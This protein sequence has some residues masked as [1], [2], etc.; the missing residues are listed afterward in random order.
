MLRSTVSRFR[1]SIVVLGCTVLGASLATCWRATDSG[2]AAASAAE[3]A[4]AAGAEIWQVS[5]NCTRPFFVRAL[6]RTK[7]ELTAYY[8]LAPEQVSEARV[9]LSG[10]TIPPVADPTRAAGLRQRQAAEH[11]AALHVKNAEWYTHVAELE[12]QQSRWEQRLRNIA[13]QKVILGEAA[14]RSFHDYAAGV[15]GRAGA[16]G[17]FDH[18]ALILLGL[19]GFPAAEEQAI[20]SACVTVSPVRQ[21]TVAANAFAAFWP[22]PIEHIAAVAFGLQ[23]VLLGLLLIPTALW[24]ATGDLQAAKQHI[25]LEAKMLLAR[26]REFDGEK[27]VANLLSA[28]RSVRDFLSSNGTGCSDLKWPP[29]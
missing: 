22:T 14:R 7:G 8:N 13:D 12:I 9:R 29:L 16:K 25:H 1:L 18:Y 6:L 10:E 27:F 5:A 11:N 2:A 15:A 21:A 23:L 28:L 20:E 3:N 26:L 19:G 24:I 4:A 17:D